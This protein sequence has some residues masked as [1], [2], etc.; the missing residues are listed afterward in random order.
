MGF[1]KDKRAGAYP[2]ARRTGVFEFVFKSGA[3]GFR[4]GITVGTADPA[5]AGFGAISVEQC[6]AICGRVLGVQ[7]L[8]ER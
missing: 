7:G 4:H 5:H 6:M 3:K 1:D 8:S 2:A